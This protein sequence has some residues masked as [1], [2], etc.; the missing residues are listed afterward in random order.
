[1][2]APYG[3]PVFQVGGPSV[4]TCRNAVERGKKSLRNRCGPEQGTCAEIAAKL[5]MFRLV[6]LVAR[7][8]MLELVL[9]TF[10]ITYRASCCQ[11]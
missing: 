10:R 2:G 11:C 9:A 3:R 6:G 8:A 1:M 5:S 7:H 4:L